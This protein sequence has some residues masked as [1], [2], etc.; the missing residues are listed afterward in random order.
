MLRK[1][2]NKG[3]GVSMVVF[4]YIAIDVVL[5]LPTQYNDFELVLFWDQFS[6]D[7]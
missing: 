7:P 2:G 5:Y 1:P 3:M 4:S 6:I